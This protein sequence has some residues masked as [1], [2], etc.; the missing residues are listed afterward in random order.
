[1]KSPYFEFNNSG[2]F[3]FNGRQLVY[4]QLYNDFEI[5]VPVYKINMNIIL[6]MIKVVIHIHNVYIQAVNNMQ[7]TETVT[8]KKVQTFRERIVRGVV[9]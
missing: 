4:I 2:K 6:T 5:L 1:M 9:E 8:M 3:Y 7:K